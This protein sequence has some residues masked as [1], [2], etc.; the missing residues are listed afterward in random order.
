L[1]ERNSV[2]GRIDR[3]ELDESAP[4]FGGDG[5]FLI[6]ETAGMAA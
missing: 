3:L 2:E 6:G 4:V 1:P 5:A